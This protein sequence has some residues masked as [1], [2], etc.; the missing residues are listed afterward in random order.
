MEFKAFPKIGR[1]SKLATV[2]EKIDGTN[3]VVALFELSSEQDPPLAYPVVA[4]PV[5]RAGKRWAVLAGSRNRW[6]TTESTRKGGDNFGFASWVLANAHELLSLG[7]GYHY[8]EW[9]GA[10]IQRGYGLSEKRFSL[11]NV[12]RWGAD[13]PNTPSCCSV[14]PVLSQ[15]A[16][17]DVDD[18]MSVLDIYGSQAAPGF[19]K[20]EGIV[21]YHEGTMY[22][23]TF[24]YDKGKW[25]A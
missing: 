21:I 7:A 22:K 1:L 15:C 2:T 9:W 10:G 14:V 16:L 18:L 25:A 24:E 8:G 13:N 17:A 20:P 19:M 4:L 6:L 3:A 12:A 11:F 5:D 23:K